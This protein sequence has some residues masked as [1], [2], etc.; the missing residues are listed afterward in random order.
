MILFAFFLS[1]VALFLKLTIY[2]TLELAPFIPFL[3]VIS[4]LRPF[5]TALPLAA[6]AGLIIDLLSSDPLGIHALNYSLC[7]LICYRSRW[8]FSAES[9]LQLGLYTALYSFISTQLQI[10]LLFLFDRRVEFLGKW[11][12]VQ[13][14]SL[15]LIDAAYALIWFAGPLALTRAL[16]RY[17]IVYWLKKKDQNLTH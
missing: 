10:A 5:T 3:A 17:W 11:W 16:H 2:P 6:L 12:I 13:W 9:P 15:P 7:L 14:F 1:L 8:L 4:L